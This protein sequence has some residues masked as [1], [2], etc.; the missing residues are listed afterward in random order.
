M[1]WISNCALS[2]TPM[3]FTVHSRDG[4]M[5]AVRSSRTGLGTSVCNSPV[6]PPVLSRWRNLKQ[7]MRECTFSGCTT[8]EGSTICLEFLEIVPV[9]LCRCAQCAVTTA[10]LSRWVSYLTKVQ[11]VELRRG[12]RCE[13]LLCLRRWVG[14][15]LPPW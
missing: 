4:D 9:W 8:F 13:G 1:K 3:Q 11:G 12:M 7:V 14:R 2:S 15:A 10:W 5:W 6:L